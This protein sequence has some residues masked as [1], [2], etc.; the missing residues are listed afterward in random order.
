MFSKRAIVQVRETVVV[1]AING[2]AKHAST[3][4]LH[5]HTNYA[6]RLRPEVRANATLENAS[7]ATLHLRQM[8]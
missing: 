4:V 8:L 7:N 1:V 6:Q 3:L 2:N 5:T